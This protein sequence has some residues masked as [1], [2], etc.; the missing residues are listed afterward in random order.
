MELQ[1]I[2]DLSKI[3]PGSLKAE[4]MRGAILAEIFLLV[5]TAVNLVIIN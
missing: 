3:I 1:D 4:D 2:I 5:G